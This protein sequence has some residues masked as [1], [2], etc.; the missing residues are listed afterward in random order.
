[1]AKNERLEGSKKMNDINQETDPAGN[2][3]GILP[4]A[5]TDARDHNTD[6]LLRAWGRLI[7]RRKAAR[8]SSQARRS[9]EDRS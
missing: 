8:P 3:E 7:A 2:A 5:G 4:D 9:D 1:M 6:L